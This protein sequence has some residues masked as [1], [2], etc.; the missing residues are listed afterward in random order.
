L[1][2]WLR[3]QGIEAYV[4]HPSS[5]SVSREHRRAKTDRLDTEL[6]KRA[7]LGWLRSE[8]KHCSMA[9]IP[10][11]EDEDARRPSRER[12]SLVKEC[13][14]I[15]NRVKAGL[16]SRASLEAIGDFA[17]AN[18]ASRLLEVAKQQD[19]NVVVSEALY[20]A[21][22]SSGRSRRSTLTAWAVG[23]RPRSASARFR[24]ATRQQC[25]AESRVCQGTRS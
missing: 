17:H 11:I 1:A 22:K 2:R 9:A 19:S 7:F 18:V 6:L 13:T 10:T 5:V 8:P 14:R 25:S 16:D 21:V 15:V 23:K 24:D 4:I 20:R 12:Q 3:A